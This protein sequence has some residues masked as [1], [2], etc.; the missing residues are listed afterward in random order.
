[1]CMSHFS[2][3]TF[4][5]IILFE[6]KFQISSKMRELKIFIFIFEESFSKSVPLYI[7]TLRI[8]KLLPPRNSNLII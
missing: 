2:H 1:M 5:I 4:N 8:S 7:N 3:E 6:I